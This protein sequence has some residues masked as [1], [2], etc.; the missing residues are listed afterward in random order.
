MIQETLSR[1]SNPAITSDRWHV[2]LARW[3]GKSKAD[4]RFTRS[5]VSEHD[6]HASAVS[7]ARRMLTSRADEMAKTP[8]ATRDQILVRRP[9]Y[10][11]L[12]SARRRE[13]R[14]PR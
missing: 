2:I 13:R 9:A 1:N 5:I 11:S 7:A 8:V 14:G 3:S 10:K 4:P 12:V 6:D